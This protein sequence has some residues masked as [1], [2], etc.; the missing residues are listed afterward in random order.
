MST[1]LDS[2]ASPAAPVVSSFPPHI[3]FSSTSLTSP[4]PPA[5]PAARQQRVRQSHSVSAAPSQ[6]SP[7]RF[8]TRKH[9]HQFREEMGKQLESLASLSL[10]DHVGPC[11]KCYERGKE[12]HEKQN[13]VGQTNRRIFLDEPVRPPSQIHCPGADLS[14]A[15]RRAGNTSVRPA[16]ALRSCRPD[17]VRRNA[18]F[19]LAKSSSSPFVLR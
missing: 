10:A 9:L 6:T 13:C 18:S 8:A 11:R 2:L 3:R 7:S 19:P 15:S 14:V 16:V 12:R 5:Q 1:R 17:S 4:P